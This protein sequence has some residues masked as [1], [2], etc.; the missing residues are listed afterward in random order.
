MSYTKWTLVLVGLFLLIM[1]IMGLLPEETLSLGTEPVWHAG[2]KIV[3]GL[4]A[5]A[6]PFV[7]K[8]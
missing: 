7:D 6:V 8:S 2:L 3:I 1:G 5:M 4:I